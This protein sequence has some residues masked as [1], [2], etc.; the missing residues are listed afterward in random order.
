MFSQ[1]FNCREAAIIHKKKDYE[2]R[3]LKERKD[4]HAEV[5]ELKKREEMEDKEL[6]QW[7]LMQGLKRDEI[8]KVHVIK[9]KESEW[10]TKMTVRDGYN[11]QIVSLMDG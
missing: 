5:E 2:A 7:V 9:R 1:F 6:R 8:D 4:Y 3:L 11:K 10:A